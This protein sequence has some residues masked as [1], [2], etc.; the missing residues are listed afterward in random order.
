MQPK[1]VYEVPVF[2]NKKLKGY[3]TKWGLLLGIYPTEIKTYIHTQ[4]L[5]LN[6]YSSTIHNKQKPETI[7]MSIIW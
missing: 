4:S 1:Q 5:Y 7:Q 2:A 3:K 6:V